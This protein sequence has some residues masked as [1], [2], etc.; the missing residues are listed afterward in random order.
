M[1][2]GRDTTVTRHARSHSKGRLT[3]VADRLQSKTGA[4]QGGRQVV[5]KPIPIIRKWIRLQERTLYL[6]GSLS[7]GAEIASVRAPFIS[8][9]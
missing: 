1:V 6:R 4:R 8:S 7:K 2:H 9:R 3:L 5:S